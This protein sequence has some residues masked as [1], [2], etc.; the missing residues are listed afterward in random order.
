MIF[1]LK[2][3]LSNF[4]DFFLYVVVFLLFT[5]VADFEYIHSHLNFLFSVTF[6]F[7]FVCPIILFRNTLGKQ[8]VNLQWLGKEGLKIQLFF[9]YLV[10]LVF[11]VPALN[12]ITIITEF[13]YWN[14]EIINQDASFVIKISIVFLISDILVSL[15]SLGK[16]HILDYFLKIKLVNKTYSSNMYS[17]LSIILLLSGV[18]LILSVYQY[19]YSFTFANISE[20]VLRKIPKESFPID[21][22]HGGYVMAIHEKSNKTYVP[23]EPLSLIYKKELNRKTIYVRLPIDIFNSEKHRRDICYNILEYSLSNDIFSGYKPDQTRFILTAVEDG[24]FISYN[25]YRYYYYFDRDLPE[26]GIYG[27][28][29]AD[30]TTTDQYIKFINNVR[31]AKKLRVEE[32]FKGSFR[33]IINRALNDSILLEKVNSVYA[34]RYETRYQMSGLSIK[35]DTSE[36]N[37]DKIEFEDSKLSGYGHYN[38]PVENAKNNFFTI[39]AVNDEYLLDDENVTQLEF[40]IENYSNEY[41]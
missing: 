13:P 10:Y 26:W 40:I 14:K 6:I 23:T 39:Q 41:L 38:F 7:V 33:E 20:R 27:G 35:I 12:P 22:V 4:I 17:S 28:I 29:K 9:K 37:L 3:L 5:I 21:L 2:R 19:K 8:I 15:I 1:L 11:L 36:I 24:F 25:E 30:S 32:K 18:Y 16:F 31:L 34:S